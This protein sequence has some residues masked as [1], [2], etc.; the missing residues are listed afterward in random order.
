SHTTTSTGLK[1]KCRLDHKKYALGKI[2]S[3]QE[4]NSLNLLR[5]KFYGEWNYTLFNK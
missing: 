3:D 1:V 5:E 2:V 4:M